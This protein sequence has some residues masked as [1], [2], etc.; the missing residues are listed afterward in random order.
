MKQRVKNIDWFLLDFL[1]E[2]VLFIKASFID[3]LLVN[4]VK[5]RGY[6]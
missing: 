5:G 2:N 6:A 1:V 3:C 4:D